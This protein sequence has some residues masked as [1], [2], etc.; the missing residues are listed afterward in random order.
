[1]SNGDQGF[2]G[3]RIKELGWR[4][5]SILPPKL[6]QELIEADEFRLPE[7]GYTVLIVISHDCDITNKKLADEPLAELLVVQVLPGDT[8]NGLLVHGRHPRRLQFALRIDGVPRIAEARAH[9]RF[10]I[11]RSR[12]M[13]HAP[14]S[15]R[16][17]EPPALDEIVLW[18]TK[19][20][21][22]AAFPDTFNERIRKTQKSIA[23]AL[24]AHGHDVREIFIAMSSWEEL[25]ADQSYEVTL[26]ATMSV[27]DF[28][29]A[30]KRQHA[31]T[32]LD[33]IEEKLQSCAGIE[34]TDATLNS[35]ADVSLDDLP[36]MKRFDY[37][38]LSADEDVLHTPNHPTP[39]ER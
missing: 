13:G 32:A 15:A 34:I 14:D 4:Q 10:F 19:R 30:G 5:G 26:V 16:T 11:D 7:A 18:L 31:Q 20:Y 39:D 35:D 37:D 12:L 38:Y 36:L 6:C 25:Q 17:C 33:A 24:A 1:M 3:A 21:N 8:T 29:E 23:T 28:D 22:R 27:E 9:D 2:D